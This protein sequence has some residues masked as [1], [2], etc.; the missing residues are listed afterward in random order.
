MDNFLFLNINLTPRTIKKY[1]K[2]KILTYRLGFVGP[3][4]RK[5]TFFLA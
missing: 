2:K 1:C 5:H 4:D 3:Y